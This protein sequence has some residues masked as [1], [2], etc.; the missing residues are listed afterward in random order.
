VSRPQRVLII[1]DHDDSREMLARLLRREGCDVTHYNNCEAAERHIEA[2]D[3]DVALLDV[4]MPDRCGDDFGSELCRRCPQTMI[5]F[6]TAVDGIAL[7][8]EAVPDCFVLRKP[9]EM[10][11]LLKLLATFQS[12]PRGGGPTA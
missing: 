2:G 7:L 12:A 5:V 6:V 1:E 4:E 8:K 10:L 11:V 9:V 3:V